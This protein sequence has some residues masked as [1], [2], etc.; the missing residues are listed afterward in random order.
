MQCLIHQSNI[1]KG[2]Q[3]PSGQINEWRLHHINWSMSIGE[4]NRTIEI[5]NSTFFYLSALFSHDKN[6]CAIQKFFALKH[7]TSIF[8]T[9][10]KNGNDSKS[11]QMKPQKIFNFFAHFIFVPL[12]SQYIH[13]AADLILPYIHIFSYIIRVYV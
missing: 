12:L 3:R 6:P 10:Q 4:W 1:V 13:N 2:W 5:A 8:Y 9:C 7:C 11:N